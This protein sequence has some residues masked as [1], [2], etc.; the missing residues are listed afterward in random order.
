MMPSLHMVSISAKGFSAT[1]SWVG[2]SRRL[3]FLNAIARS[4]QD[5]SELGGAERSIALYA[6]IFTRFCTA[7]CL[8]ALGRCLIRQFRARP[9]S[10][11]PWRSTP[12]IVAQFPIRKKSSDPE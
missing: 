4:D 7:Q 12:L 6:R 3:Q 2:F 1:V 10:Q 9:H 11:G 8:D 5:V